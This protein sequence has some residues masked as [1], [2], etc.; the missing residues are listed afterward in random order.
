MKYTNPQVPSSYRENDL[1]RT[2]YDLVMNLKPTKILEFGVL[3]GYSTIAMAMALHEIGAGK[4]YAYDLWDK[5]PFKH[6]NR[7]D[8]E[9]NI[10]SYGLQD[11]VEIGTADIHLFKAEPFSLMHLDVSND[12]ALLQT[13]VE[14][15]QPYGEAIVFEGGTEERD[16]VEWMKKYKKTPM[17]GALKFEVLNEKFPG[18]SLVRVEK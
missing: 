1:G 6:A 17:R 13:L 7:E 12:G 3:H 14:K 9:K 4:V 16:N 10:Q 18:L 2:L 11:F 8:T 15:F 5:Y